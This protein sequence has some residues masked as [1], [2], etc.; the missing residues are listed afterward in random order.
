MPAND[1]ELMQNLDQIALQLEEAKLLI[2]DEVILN[3]QKQ[4][5]KL[6][7]NIDNHTC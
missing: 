1:K 7:S 6:K 2:N 4:V 5:Q 3:F